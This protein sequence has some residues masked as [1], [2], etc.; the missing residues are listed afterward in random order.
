VPYKIEKKR[1]SVYISVKLIEN[2]IDNC[3]E[4]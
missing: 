4:K 3:R 1:E 2:R